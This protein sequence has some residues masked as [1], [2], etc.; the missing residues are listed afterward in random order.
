MKLSP[1]LTAKLVATGIGLLLLALASISLTLWVTWNMQGGAAA[2]NEAGRMR[3]QTYRLALSLAS[4]ADPAQ[5]RALAR[6]F[7]ESIALLETGDPSRPLFVP[8]SAQSRERFAAV[9]E[10]WQVLRE[11]WLAGPPPAALREQS[12]AFVALIDGF[13]AAIETHIARW[14]TLLQMFQLALVGLAVIAAVVMFYSGYLFV[15]QPL[16]R[17]KRGLAALQAGELGTRVEAGSRDEFGELAAGFN[18]MAGTLQSLYGELEDKVRQKTHSLELKRERLAQLYEVSAFVA[19]APTLDALAEGFARHARRIARAA[20]CAVR[21]CDKDGR[22][23]LLV[24]HD[25]MPPDVA[26]AEA[27]LDSGS[28]HCGDLTAQSPTRV[29]PVAVARRPSLGHCRRA[30]FAA[31]VSVPVRVHERLLCEVDLFYRE[32]IELSTEDRELLEALASHLA[33]ALESLRAAALEREAAVAEERSLLARELHDSIAQSLLF[34]KIQAGLV[35]QAAQRS[36]NAAVERG[37]AELQTGVRDC[38][39][40]VRELLLHFRIRTSE[41][42]IEPALRATL[43]KFEHQTG[44]PAQLTVEGHGMPLPP[45]VQVQ[46]LHILQEALS[47]VRKHA[48]ARHVEVRA[49]SVPHWHF[50]VHDDGAGFEPARPAADATHVGLRI[51]QERAL[52]IGARVDV[53]SA[54]GAGCTVTLDLPPTGQAAR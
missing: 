51:M 20:G 3:M 1:T 44:L 52:R 33:S 28:C 29:I 34:M 4:G 41:E 48:H 26:A 50:E 18:D 31:V 42:D 27:C 13:V 15:L 49:S 45:D 37:I 36:D 22:R 32:P 5:S 8:W 47:N 23:F 53:R 54:P 25:G 39:A 7:D 35:R 12:A 43:Q 40:D 17:L 6:S 21:L 9:L 14:T 2:V 24:A 11:E 38:Y 46:V 30:G 16:A 19:E 10:R